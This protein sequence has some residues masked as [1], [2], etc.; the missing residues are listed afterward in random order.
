ML[1]VNREASYLTFLTA[2]MYIRIAIR[3]VADMITLFQKQWP[4]S[5]NCWTIQ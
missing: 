1:E 4:N 5:R 2:K 3:Q